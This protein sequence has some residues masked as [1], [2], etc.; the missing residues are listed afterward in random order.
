MSSLKQRIDSYQQVSDYKLLNKLPIIITVN[1][2]NFFK[3]TSLLDK[4][5]SDLFAEAM[6]STTMKLCSEIEGAVFAYQHNDEIV[7]IARNDQSLETEAWYDN[8][9][10][11]IA[12]ATASIATFNFQNFALANDLGIIG[13]SIFT[14]SVFSVPNISEVINTIIYYQQFNF[15]K[16]IQFAC[17]YELLK[18]YDKN[19]IKDMLTGLS[20]DE[21][22]N[23]LYQETN[24]EFNSYP[25]IFRRGAACYKIPKITDH[26][27]VK[28]K[29]IINSELPIFTK[30]Q[31]FLSN[32]LKNG[33][34][35]FRS[36]SF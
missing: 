14:S 20:I 30:D 5:Y 29:W 19:T 10:Q 34:D 9:I 17:F 2:K 3:L 13:D 24:I 25:L 23:L 22:I 31:S 18:K 11:K 7:I 15:H 1:G 21:K 36:N 4:P 26:G 33:S 32:I 8:K 12:S 28:N 27:N 6:Y 35:L 16:S